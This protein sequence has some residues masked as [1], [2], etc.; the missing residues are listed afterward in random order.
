MSSDESTR[1]ARRAC[2]LCGKRDHK[3]TGEH[4]LGDW[5]TRYVGP[6]NYVAAR[7]AENPLR[8]KVEQSWPTGKVA[9]IKVN[10]IC[11]ECN[12]RMADAIETPVQPILKP[13]ISGMHVQ[14]SVDDQAAL[15]QWLYKIAVLFRYVE[16]KPREASRHELDDLLEAGR[17]R[18]GTHIFVGH[19]RG[20]AK[21][22][23]GAHQVGKLRVLQGPGAI[24][25]LLAR[26]RVRQ[27]EYQEHVVVAAGEFCAQVS[28]YPPRSSFTYGPNAALMRQIWPSIG[29]VGWPPPFHLDDGGLASLEDLTLTS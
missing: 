20:S 15:A 9:E 11:D 14:L 8:Q 12:G 7:T 17:P 24:E 3:I 5:L 10:D 26:I 29:A 25:E 21:I 19:Y 28:L 13:M 1:S 2:I 23:V 6:G 18:P 16:M 27:W 4:I 22:R